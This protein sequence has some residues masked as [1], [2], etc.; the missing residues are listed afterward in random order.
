M[1]ALPCG[2]RGGGGQLRS[3]LSGL[4][5]SLLLITLPVLVLDQVTKTLIRNHLRLSDDIVL[6]PHWLDITYALNPGAAFSLL[7]NAPPWVHHWFLIGLSGG[8]IV[9]LV[10]LLWQNS[11][12]GVIN[13]ALAL[14]LAGACG[15]LIDRL[16]RG[17]V[18]DFILMHYYSHDYPIFNV[19]D[20]AITIGVG[21]LLISSLAGG[22][23]APEPPSPKIKA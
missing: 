4:F 3:R 12:P 8:A 7:T 6:I 23:P 5:R 9:V 2:Y 14:I 17:M 10:I 1:P 21:L 20:S 19:A 16:S 11:H 15:N 22:Q 18:T 13:T